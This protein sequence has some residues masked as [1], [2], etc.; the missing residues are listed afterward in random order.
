MATSAHVK[1]EEMVAPSDFSHFLVVNVNTF[2]APLENH[3]TSDSSE[4][5]LEMVALI[6]NCE[7]LQVESMFHEWGC[8]PN[9]HKNI[10]KTFSRCNS[11]VQ[12]A[13]SIQNVI[14]TFDL[15]VRLSMNNEG[16]KNSPISPDERIIRE[17]KQENTNGVEFIN[18]EPFADAAFDDDLSSTASPLTS[19]S[20]CISNLG[21]LVDNFPDQDDFV[22]NEIGEKRPTF[23]LPSEDNCK[24]EGL[25]YTCLELL[26][27]TTKMLTSF[28]PTTNLKSFLITVWGNW[29]FQEFLGGKT[30]CEL[31]SFCREWCDIKVIYRECIDVLP[32]D[33]TMPKVMATL[34]ISEEPSSHSSSI[35]ECIHIAKIAA[36]LLS[37]RANFRPTFSLEIDRQV[38]SAGAETKRSHTSFPLKPS[39][40]TVNAS[41]APELNSTA[42]VIDSSPTVGNS[43]DE[44]QVLVGS[45]ADGIKTTRDQNSI[46]QSTTPTS[47]CVIPSSCGNGTS[48]RK[49]CD[50]KGSENTFVNETSLN[51]SES[52]P[53][54]KDQPSSSDVSGAQSLVSKSNFVAC[55]QASGPSV[56]EGKICVTIRAKNA[57]ELRQATPHFDQLSHGALVMPFSS[58]QKYHVP[59]GAAYGPLL[60]SVELDPRSTLYG[61]PYVN[62]NY[63]SSTAARVLAPS[64]P[65]YNIHLPVG[66]S[67]PDTDYSA[68]VSSLSGSSAAS[69]CHGIDV[70]SSS[71]SYLRDSAAANTCR[72]V[73][74]TAADASIPVS[75]SAHTATATLNVPSIKKDTGNSE[76][77]TSNT[78]SSVPCHDPENHANVADLKDVQQKLEQ[79]TSELNAVRVLLQQNQGYQELQQYQMQQ[80]LRQ[81]QLQQMHEHFFYQQQMQMVRS[82]A[83]QPLYYPNKHYN[84]VNQVNQQNF[85]GYPI[86]QY[87]ALPMPVVQH[88]IPFK[89]STASTPVSVEALRAAGDMYS[90][91]PSLPASSSAN[92]HVV[93]SESS[94][95]VLGVKLLLMVSQ[96]PA[97]RRISSSRYFCEFL[98]SINRV[99]NGTYFVLHEAASSA[100]ASSPFGGVR[101][102]Q[103]HFPWTHTKTS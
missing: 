87:Q 24:D 13:D 69:F 2:K 27:T 8:L 14:K 11:N 66:S 89:P 15:W 5:F 58:I 85:L 79:V 54:N 33:V 64:L 44:T 88:L 93:R 71:C 3:R 26:S 72:Y 12:A 61:A 34:G 47:E 40:E 17:L 45:V 21:D 90:F 96:P 70:K 29:H 22:T 65:R 20:E 38:S 84:A 95:G 98:A 25:E 86:F 1:V 32:S 75:S 80:F 31:P 81:Q 68:G 101:I 56:D 55:S 102:L 53:Q 18:M 36:R 6:L 4:N 97:E 39:D 9:D 42:E 43:V 16:G 41:D 60:N 19:S 63:M 7:S 46:L 77:A 76:N 10:S 52:C 23:E 82:N 74:P 51:E 67:A 94:L 48:S 49:S 100:V 78:E 35:A 28:W 50:D 30:N 59:R 103:F 57:E 83:P 91:V 92:L 37:I 62:M 99:K 73:T